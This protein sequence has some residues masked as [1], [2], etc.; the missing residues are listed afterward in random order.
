MRYDFTKWPTDTTKR[1]GTDVKSLEAQLASLATDEPFQLWMFRDDGESACVLANRR[2][3]WLSILRRDADD[4]LS[5]DQDF[6]GPQD[7]VEEIYLENGQ[8]DEM[9]RAHCIDRELA[10]AAGLHYFRTGTRAPFVS[11][12]P[13]DTLQ[14]A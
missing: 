12:F 13:N 6:D 11:W 2:L 8:L 7:T 3:A 14:Q 1:T 5:L 9:L 10:I 4:I